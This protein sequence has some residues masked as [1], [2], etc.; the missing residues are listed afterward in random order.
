MAVSDLAGRLRSSD[1]K[2]TTARGELRF[3]RSGVRVPGGAAPSRGVSGLAA[4][5]REGEQGGLA[6]KRGEIENL[7]TEGA[8]KDEGLFGR[9]VNAVQGG[10]AQLIGKIADA[11]DTFSGATF[12]RAGVNELIDPHRRHGENK[13]FSWDD[14]WA[15]AMNNISMSE[16]LGQGTENTRVRNPSGVN[17]ISNRAVR[18][19][20]GFGGDVAFDPLT[21]ATFGAS[22]A[23]VTPGKAGAAGAA[24]AVG[25]QAVEEGAEAVARTAG[26]K[27]G[28]R[29]T[30]STEGVARRLL[31]VGRVADAEKV[32]SQRAA[33]AASREALEAAGIDV[34]MR[35]RVG[36]YSTPI[37]PG[38]RGAAR[39]LGRAG[40]AAKRAV[41]R[42]R[43]GT[44]ALERGAF[45]GKKMAELWRNDPVMGLIVK[46][47]QRLGRGFGAA[48]RREGLHQLDRIFDAYKDIDGP[49]LARA[50]ED[51]EFRALADPRVQ[52]AQAALSGW[53]EV[54]RQ[55]ASQ[56]SGAPIPKFED[57]LPHRLTNEFRE[58]LSDAGKH[59]GR[60]GS[61][62]VASTQARQHR[63]GSMWFG[64]RL[65]TGSLAEM[66]DIAKR[67][68]GPS[69]RKVFE[70]NPWMLAAT[71]MHGME[72]HIAY[73]RLAQEVAERG[74]A[75]GL[76]G[77]I[78]RYG[79]GQLGD[80]ESTVKGAADIADTARTRGGQEIGRL[81]RA[82]GVQAEDVAELPT[83]GRSEAAQ[84]GAQTRKAAAAQADQ[85]DVFDLLND[86]YQEEL[87][88]SQRAPKVDPGDVERAVRDARR[89]VRRT[90][91]A[92][93]DVTGGRNVADLIPGTPTWRRAKNAER[94]VLAATRTAEF[95]EELARRGVD[96]STTRRFV[97]NA[98]RLV[99]EDK[100]F[101]QAGRAT[102]RRADAAAQIAAR[103]AEL[104][105]LI[106]TLEGRARELAERELFHLDNAAKLR[107]ASREAKDTKL[108]QIADL[109][110][111]AQEHMAEIVSMNQVAQNAEAFGAVGQQFVD[112]IRLAM[113]D[114]LTTLT[115]NGNLWADQ[116]T[117][118]AILA[119]D[120]AMK[121]QHVKGLL[122]L[123]DALISRWK[124][125]ALLSPG[126]HTRNYIGG[127]FNNALANIDSRMYFRFLKA[128]RQFH[129]A[130]E[131][132][133]FEAGIAAISNPEMREAYR[134]GA[135]REVW[136]Q[137]HLRGTLERGVSDEATRNVRDQA[138]IASL[139]AGAD[140][141]RG[142][143]RTGG[144]AARFDPTN[145]EFAPY[146]W[147][148]SAAESVE[149]QV[150]GSLF[151][152][153]I[154]KGS[155]ADE[156]LSDVVRYHFDYSE[157]SEFEVNVGRRL[158]PFYTWTRKNFPLQLEE[159][160]RNPGRYTAFF[161]A[162][163]AIEADS[164][165]EGFVPTWLE[166]MGAIHLPVSFNGQDPTYIAVDT[167]FRD[168]A[169][170]L[171][172][173]EAIGMTNPL[174]KTLVELSTGRQVGSDMIDLP[175]GLDPVPAVLQPFA[176]AFAVLPKIPGFS[177]P[178]RDPATG[179]WL[180]EGH[181]IYKF[182]Q[183]LP[184]L[185]R[186]RRIAPATPRDQRRATASW[187]SFLG[188]STY[189]LDEPMQ[190][191]AASELAEEL[192]A[193][194]EDYDVTTGAYGEA[195]VD[196]EKVAFGRE[197][198]PLPERPRFRR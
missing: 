51:P 151:V 114:G 165:E 160:V 69:Y 110:A 49:T 107:Q 29:L 172:P 30:L 37:L 27:A 141:R 116:A 41:A 125:Q 155:S 60:G 64:E 101:N 140:S 58:E 115:K 144:R 73:N 39:G 119:V 23:V 163:R 192:A 44:W 120:E 53:F 81:G 183:A 13:T 99:L 21:Y 193:M 184:V 124:A 85:A 150:R 173:D 159:M 118:D 34:G 109:E 106:P 20:L 50:M 123:H 121:P 111:Q 98:E 26:R 166:K 35:L 28:Q 194:I 108:Q 157:L 11:V 76:S 96:E 179:T 6:G 168:L 167:P 70:D 63:V 61:K 8:G 128:D 190:Y 189:T 86:L 149:R 17:A 16:Y 198:T 176:A 89:T 97:Q 25:R 68:L 71:Y 88:L 181:D 196:P 186:L 93:A 18:S 56:I 170:T 9:M 158:I 92:L 54:A 156:A 188:V 57:Y 62:N 143:T 178:V 10:G 3:A 131:R 5:L 72:R 104:G 36:R 45:G 48:E 55:R 4:R 90:Q 75:L 79:R 130:Y 102:A 46:D 146:A 7:L 161:H 77:R 67:A 174:V 82:L 66:E 148:R 145:M 87:R 162:K 40:G 80:L 164:Q 175:E 2:N 138:D 52:E 139:G 147:N 153:R 19:V 182:E 33:T 136:G 135:E 191:G 187:L 185:S 32:L 47:S 14:L 154:L 133:G 38:T 84:A 127:L 117:A 197:I 94:I 42:S 59:G 180:W 122:K 195:S 43:P 112:E 152:D 95:A 22:S 12:I 74:A 113:H 126:Y 24:R 105:T 169:T 78:T 177:K 103:Q 132:G 65:Q 83:V 134:L 1:D 31:E 15:N 100:V 171:D 91:R 129:R 142:I 137:A